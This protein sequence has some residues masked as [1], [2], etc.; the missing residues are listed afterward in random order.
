MKLHLISK[1]VQN[2]ILIWE[3]QIEIIK[4]LK[5]IYESR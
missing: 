4:K 2:L 5:K 3:L 1:N